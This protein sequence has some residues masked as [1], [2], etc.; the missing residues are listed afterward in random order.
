MSVN[1]HAPPGT[2]TEAGT[3]TP[4]TPTPGTPTDHAP[5][6]TPTEAGCTAELSS[7]MRPRLK[8]A[9][10]WQVELDGGSEGGSLGALL[11]ALAQRWSAH[12][13][14][15]CFLCREKVWTP[16]CATHNARAHARARA[17]T[18]TM[19]HT[20]GRDSG[21]KEARGPPADR[22]LMQDGMR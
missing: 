13:T 16:L 17:H 21:D 6:G 22:A 15:T 2:P 7:T 19:A 1:D 12:I 10:S 20:Q 4:G 9:A 14:S 8:G 11:S 5:P 18:H 3:P